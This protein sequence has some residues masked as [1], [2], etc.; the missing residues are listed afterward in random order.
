MDA[1]QV[2]AAV[3]MLR[4]F[5]LAVTAAQP[6]GQQMTAPQRMLDRLSQDLGPAVDD[7]IGKIRALVQ[8]AQ[9]LDE[10]RDGLEQLLPGMSLD[11]YAA[12]MA[13]ALRAARLAGRYDVLQ[14][15]GGG[16]GGA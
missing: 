4:P 10:I 3:R 5:G 9:S 14:E 7:W 1:G 13:E 2:A 15:A 12:A 11:Q 8:R 16:G 6:H